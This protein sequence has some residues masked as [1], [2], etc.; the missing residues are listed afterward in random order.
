M[1]KSILRWIE[2]DNNLDEE[3][4]A[5]ISFGVDQMLNAGL[6][7]ISLILLG[8]IMNSWKESVIFLLLFIPLRKYAGGYHADT[9]IRCYMLTNLM[10][11]LSIQFYKLFSGSETEIL[12][13]SIVLSVLVGMLSPV[14]NLN[15]LLSAKQKRLYQAKMLKRVK[16]E[17]FICIFLQIIGI[18]FVLQIEL[19]VLLL[20]LVLQLLGILKKQVIGLSLKE[21]ISR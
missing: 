15:N 2:R 10:F 18:Q 9:K 13:F 11:V 8:I 6:N 12:F 20:I 7:L 1:N 17:I 4:K 3:N 5:I 21:G 16:I 19:C 14:D